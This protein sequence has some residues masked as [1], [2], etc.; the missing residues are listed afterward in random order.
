MTEIKLEPGLLHC[1]ETVA[2]NE[3]ERVLAILLQGREDKQLEDELELL[4]LFLESE[5]FSSL[6]TRCEDLLV[7]GKRVT[8][9]LRWTERNRSYGVQ[10]E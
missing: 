9:T 1:I 7:A 8:V 10:I 6:R 4:R 2:K 5:D 3:Y